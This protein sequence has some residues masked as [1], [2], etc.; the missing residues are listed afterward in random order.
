MRAA[1]LESWRQVVERRGNRS[2]SDTLV[3]Q[4]A[5]KRLTLEVTLDAD[6][7]LLNTRVRRSSGSPALDAAAQNILRS[8]AP[9]SSFPPAL[10][11]HYQKLSFA[12]DWRFLGDIGP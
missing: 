12:Y 9:F 1:Y 8:A 7:Y 5:G 3:Q 6:G 10:R 4:S 2:L 11:A